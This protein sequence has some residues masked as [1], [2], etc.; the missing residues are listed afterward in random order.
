M[1]DQSDATITKYPWDKVYKSLEFLR[2]SI[3]P[4]CRN[5]ADMKRLLYEAGEVKTKFGEFRGERYFQGIF[6]GSA[7]WINE[8]VVKAIPK[9]TKVDMCFDLTFGIVPLGYRQLLI[10]HANIS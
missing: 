1:Q 3:Y 6:N 9:N 7:L 4:P 8:R 10:G 2:Y 5:E